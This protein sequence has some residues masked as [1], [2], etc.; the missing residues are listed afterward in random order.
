MFGD[1]VVAWG[2]AEDVP[3]DGIGDV[4]VFQFPNVSGQLCASA[5]LSVVKV[6]LVSSPSCFKCVA[7]QPSVG[8]DVTTRIETRN[9]FAKLLGSIDHRPVVKL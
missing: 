9:I 6:G 3:G 2:P 7:C 1:R 4:R 5:L 8:L